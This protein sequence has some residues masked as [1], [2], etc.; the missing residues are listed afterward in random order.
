M[1]IHLNFKSLIVVA[2][3]S[4][5]N[6]VSTS[7]NPSS[8]NDDLAPETTT[9]QVGHGYW[10]NPHLDYVST[11][12]PISHEGLVNIR[13]VPALEKGFI[14]TAPADRND[15]VIVGELG[16]DG[17]NKDMIVKLAQEM[18]D[19]LHGDFNSL[20][21]THKDKLVFES[22]YL[23]GRLNLAH[24]QASA[25]KTYTGL[26]LGRAIQ[27]GYLT[28]ADLDKPLV[29]FLKE[30]D[31]SK[32]VDGAE[33]L[34]L[35]QAL[36]MR[37][38]IRIIDEK[39]EEFEKYRDQLKGQNLVQTIFE[40]SDPIT[41][42]SQRS[43]SYGNYSTPLVMQVIDAVV[44]GT[45]EEFIKIELLG[46]MGIGTYEWRTGLGSLPAAGWKSSFSSRDMMKFGTLAINKGKWNGEQLIPEAYLSKATSRL[47]TTGDDVK[48]FGG[49]KDVSNQGYGYF[50][51]SGDLKVGDKY[52][53][54]TSAQGGSGQFIIL[55]EELDLI[56]VATGAHRGSGG[57]NLQ[58][59]A[60]RILPAFL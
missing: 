7:D 56:I 38:G 35:H 42:E 30:L 10:D 46:K 14:A 12:W 37:S 20:L 44:P 29:G 49:G 33:K 57:K 48:V 9:E 39:G 2:L 23:F 4:G 16:I 59:A 34:T 43:F 5:C 24:P 41:S 3:L 27:L 53:F 40:Q 36:T 19:G 54:S 31:S 50:W 28:M 45:A 26:A 8:A 32:F 51:W 21:I 11:A 25:T 18:S 58:I 1:T 55:V 15:G 47:V 22:Y 52:Y 13:E 6:S 60:E 17:G